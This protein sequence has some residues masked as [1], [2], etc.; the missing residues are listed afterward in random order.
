MKFSDIVGAVLLTFAS[1]A[2]AIKFDPESEDSIRAASTQYMH[3]LMSLYKGNAT[4]AAQQD[5]GIWPQPHYWWE[6]GAAWGAGTL[7]SSMTGDQSYVKTLQQALTA[8]YGPA[9]DF[10]LDYRRS[11]TVS[12]TFATLCYFRANWTTGQRRSGFLVLGRDVRA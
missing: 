5:I 11:Q 4:G 8:N 7:Y 2:K 12:L 3:G 1:T 6:G 9:N 10:I